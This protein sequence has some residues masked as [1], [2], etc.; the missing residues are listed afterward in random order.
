MKERLFCVVVI[1][2]VLFTCINIT[3][4]STSASWKPFSILRLGSVG[5]PAPNTAMSNPRTSQ[6]KDMSLAPGSAA[7]L[8]NSTAAPSGSTSN[9]RYS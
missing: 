6:D 7:A 3:I 2:L 1:L 5:L 4:T 8:V 9:T